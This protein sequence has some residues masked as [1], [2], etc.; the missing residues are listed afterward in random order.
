MSEYNLFS[1]FNITGV[2]AADKNIN[3]INFI[4]RSEI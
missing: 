3:K 4:P 2:S 1:N